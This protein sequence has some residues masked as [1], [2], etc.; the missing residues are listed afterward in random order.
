MDTTEKIS[1]FK[2]LSSL[3][4]I[5]KNFEESSKINL[6]MLKNTIL[7]FYITYFFESVSF[8]FI[9]IGNINEIILASLHKK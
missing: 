5:Y 9:F 4:N 3:V 1:Y 7:A 6:K 2:F 8:A